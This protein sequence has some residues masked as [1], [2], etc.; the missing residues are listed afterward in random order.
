M[1]QMDGVL[2]VYLLTR[3]YLSLLALKMCRNMYGSQ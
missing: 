2:L 3:L 1:I